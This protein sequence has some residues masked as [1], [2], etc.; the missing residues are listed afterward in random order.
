MAYRI[1]GLAPEAFQPLWGMNERELA[2]RNARRMTANSPTGFPCR[3]SLIDASPGENL[4]LLNH[5]SHDVPTPFRTAYAIFVR[6]GAETA[7]Y[8]D[9]APPY[10][11]TRTLGLRG[12]DGEGMLR[13]GLLA[14]PGE[15]DEKI[16]ELFG[17]PEI[18]TI[19]AHNAALGCFLAR[20]ERD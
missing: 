11:E 14:R 2:E 13:G 16:R 4:I 12:F 9:E 15:A 19:H 10:L 8:Q 3:V 20:I 1:E 7:S 6:E 18:A 5:V 17:R